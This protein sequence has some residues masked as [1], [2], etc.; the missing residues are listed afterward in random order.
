[1]CYLDAEN[2]IERA[3]VLDT[4]RFFPADSLEFGK[5]QVTNLR[6]VEKNA[7]R[8][9][10]SFIDKNDPRYV[11]VTWNVPVTRVHDKVSFTYDVKVIDNVVVYPIKR[12][13]IVEVK[14]DTLRVMLAPTIVNCIVKHNFTYKNGETGKSEK[15]A[16]IKCSLSA[17]P[18]WSEN[19][20]STNFSF[21]EA[22][23]VVYGTPYTPTGM[24]P[25]EGCSYLEREDVFTV[26]NGNGT[27]LIKCPYTFK[28]Q[29]VTIKDEFGVYDF[30]FVNPDFRQV[31]TKVSK[32]N[33]TAT[34]E[35]ARLFNTIEVSYLG[36]KH[37][38]EETVLLK[39][40]IAEYVVETKLDNLSARTDVTSDS[41][42]WSIDKVSKYS[43]G[44][45]TRQSV[46]FGISRKLSLGAAW[47]SIQTNTNHQ[48]GDYVPSLNNS[49]KRSAIIDGV[50]FTYTLKEKVYN[51]NVVLNNG[52]MVNTFTATEAEDCVAQLGNSTYSFG[53]QNVTVKHSDNVAGGAEKDGFK[54]FNY[55]DKVNYTFGNNTKSFNLNGTIKVKA[56]EEFSFPYGEVKLARQTTTLNEAGDDYMYVI[57]VQFMNG[58]VVPGFVTRGSDKVVWHLELAEQ[59]EGSNKF[60]SAVYT[61]DKGWQNCT[62]HDVY[63]A[64]YLIWYRGTTELRRVDF[65]K[66]A[67]LHWDNDY[68]RE[69]NGKNHLTVYT[70][71]FRLEI[72]KGKLYVTDKS[73]GTPLKF[74]KF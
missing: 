62:A 26:V 27:E 65:D 64:D 42:I 8:A 43:T 53:N 2:V 50:T 6:F 47:T 29:S 72:A 12:N 55:T 45:Q 68:T 46:R 25:E 31:S 44:R 67:A 11:E 56:E 14:T 52:K 74:V 7:T 35:T 28:H 49:Y 60:N 22:E 18:E 16:T 38:G 51:A 58:V 13:D 73:N 33:E 40:E 57:S 39:H 19:V 30:A 48:T 21:I 23:R 41:I 10:E 5:A 70:S 54:V 71:H 36:G 37:T 3:L 34:L 4:L 24:E 66:A 17:N 15:S 1:M 59:V 32:V 20:T 61:A 9:A 63:T 69:D